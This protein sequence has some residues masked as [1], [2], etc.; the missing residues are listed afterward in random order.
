ML[1]SKLKISGESV[2]E[3]VSALLYFSAVGRFM[4]RIL[5]A[6]IKPPKRFDLLYLVR[7]SVDPM[8]LSGRTGRDDSGNARVLFHMARMINARA[9]SLHVRGDKSER[10][11]SRYEEKRKV[12]WNERRVWIWKRKES[13]DLRVC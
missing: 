8:R 9:T 5:Y 13:R 1:S 6:S 12:D 10:V 11:S 3:A 4:G 2:R 7:R